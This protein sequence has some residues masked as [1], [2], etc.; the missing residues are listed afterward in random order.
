MSLRNPAAPCTRSVVSAPSERAE[1]DR[2]AGEPAGARGSASARY[3]TEPLA[4][5]PLAVVDQAGLDGD[6]AVRRRQKR[7]LRERAAGLL[8]PLVLQVQRR[9]EPPAER[10]A[11]ELEPLAEERARA[12]EAGRPGLGVHG[13]Q[14]VADR[15]EPAGDAGR[16]AGGRL[17]GQRR[18]DADAPRAVAADADLA[19]FEREAR[20]VGFPPRRGLGQRLAEGVERGLERRPGARE[21]PP[22]VVVHGA[23]AVERAEAAGAVAADDLGLERA[24]TLA[25]V[26]RRE[27]EAGLVGARAVVG[28]VEVGER[29]GVVH[30]ARDLAEG[31]QPRQRLGGRVEVDHAAGR[32]ARQDPKRHVVAAGRADPLVEDP[33]ERL[34]RAAVAALALPHAREADAV[35][36]VGARAGGDVDRVRLARER[37]CR[38]WC[39]EWRRSR[40]R[41][42]RGWRRRRAR[43]GRQRRRWRRGRPR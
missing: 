41:R 20:H 40:D 1:S 2:S 36:G 35:D 32:G 6:E 28:G 11:Q 31:G 13:V 34:A 25:E 43:R 38:A 8:A 24:P 10:L 15:G 33:V 19:R 12:E 30:G 27:A 7:V 9:R 23:D 4:S 21:V 17:V 37:S 29:V 39:R 26:G 14:R 22:P 5:R 16:A 18:L 42:R 3:S